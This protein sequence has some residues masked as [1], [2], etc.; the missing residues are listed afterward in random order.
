MPIL[1]E[2][3]MPIANDHQGSDTGK[4]D[5][6]WTISPML[7]PP[8]MPIRPPAEVRNAASMRNCHRI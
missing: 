5:S 3:P 8:A 7:L 2:K 6:Q 1:A 4:P